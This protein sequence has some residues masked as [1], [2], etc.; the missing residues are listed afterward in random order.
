MQAAREITRFLIKVQAAIL[1][2]Y[3]NWVNLTILCDLGQWAHAQNRS[4]VLIRVLFPFFFLAF[5]ET[6]VQL[7]CGR[8]GSCLIRMDQNFIKY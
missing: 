8:G 7:K 5:S 1:L 3:R 6:Q 4:R 2:C